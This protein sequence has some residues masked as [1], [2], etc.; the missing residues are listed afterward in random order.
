M[1]DFWFICSGIFFIGAIGVI[2]FGKVFVWISFLIWGIYF[3]KNVHMDDEKA[4]RKYK[5]Y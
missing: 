2:L 3:F 5:K 4:F 1:R